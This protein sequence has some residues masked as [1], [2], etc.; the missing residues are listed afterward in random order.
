MYPFFL[1]KWKKM[2]PICHIWDLRHSK[3]NVKKSVLPIGAIVFMSSDLKISPF[4]Q[5]WSISNRIS[6]SA[7]R[8]TLKLAYFQACFY[9]FIY[10]PNCGERGDKMC[11]MR[12]SSLDVHFRWNVDIKRV[13]HFADMYIC[14]MS[15]KQFTHFSTQLPVPYKV[16]L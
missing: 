2:K 10:F 5:S 9:F 15:P 1:S 11:Q 16:T 13:Y 4:D 12:K 8:L 6:I 3:I 7:T 14:P